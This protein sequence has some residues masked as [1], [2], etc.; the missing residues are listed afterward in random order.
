M[1]V[2]VKL[3][4]SFRDNRFAKEERQLA[5]GTTVEDVVRSL[6]I[7]LA[8]VGVTMCNSRHCELADPLAEGDQLAIFPRI[9][10]G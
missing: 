7:A 3:F 5:E 8:D 6:N 4:A 2:T 1:R 9:G 10:G